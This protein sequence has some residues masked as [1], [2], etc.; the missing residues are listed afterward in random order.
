M[1]VEVSSAAVV[2]ASQEEMS[3]NERNQAREPHTRHRYE[4]VTSRLPTANRLG[5]FNLMSFLFHAKCADLVVGKVGAPRG[6]DR[7]NTDTRI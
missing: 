2:C 3:G 7:R 4:P 1:S 6:T 5:G